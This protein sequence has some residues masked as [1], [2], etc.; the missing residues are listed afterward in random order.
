M[1]KF[2]N[3]VLMLAAA[4]FAGTATVSVIEYANIIADR[5]DNSIGGEVLIIPLMLVIL[6][7][8]WILAKMYFSIIAVSYTHLDVYKRQTQHSFQD[9]RLSTVLTV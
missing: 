1:R 6:Y 7:I 3:N 2:I 5:P 4:F 8:G 9:S